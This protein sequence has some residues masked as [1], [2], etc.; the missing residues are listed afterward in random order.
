[1]CEQASF[2]SH[3]YCIQ[4]RPSLIKECPKGVT[5]CYISVNSTIDFKRGCASKKN[6]FFQQCLNRTMD[7]C[8]TCDHD[9]CNSHPIVGL[10]FGLKCVQCEGLVQCQIQTSK[11][12]LHQN[13]LTRPLKCYT[14][15]NENGRLF[16]AGCLTEDVIIADFVKDG[17]LIFQTQYAHFE[18]STTGDF[19]CLFEDNPIICKHYGTTD[20]QGC[21]RSAGGK[22]ETRLLVH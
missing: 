18:M 20:I 6:T 2:A 19:T 3:L 7:N 4:V 21:Y 22:T 10:T 14:Q 11:D 9:Q 1:M 12:C 5:K 15:Y 16:R 17:K 8:L 13:L